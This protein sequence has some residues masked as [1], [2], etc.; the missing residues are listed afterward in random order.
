MTYSS[1]GGDSDIVVC[2]ATTDLKKCVSVP[3]A[4]CIKYVY[5]HVYQFWTGGLAIMARP[6]HMR[7]ERQTK[8]KTGKGNYNMR[9]REGG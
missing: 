1:R 8:R 5:A 2:T 9:R 7:V 4:L 6:I 3:V